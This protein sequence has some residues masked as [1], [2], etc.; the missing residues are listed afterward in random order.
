MT[1]LSTFENHPETTGLIVPHNREAEEGLLGSIFS[2]P[3]VS[4]GRC[5]FASR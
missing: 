1:H 3:D 5:F 2:Y 4:P